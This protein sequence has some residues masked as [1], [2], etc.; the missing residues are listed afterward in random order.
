[1]K[2]KCVRCGTEIEKANID[3]AK[4]IINHADKRTWG[5]DIIE[6]VIPVPLKEE[7]I[8]AILKEERI[9]MEEFLVS[10]DIYADEYGRRIIT[11]EEEIEVPKT[12]IVC[13]NCLHKDDVVI[14]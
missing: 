6:T 12:A 9:T 2:I 11:I 14:W 3:N 5:K 7:R 4:Y 8:E 10:E 1:M 13:L